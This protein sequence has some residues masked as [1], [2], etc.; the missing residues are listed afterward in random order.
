MDNQLNI[1]V[2][3]NGKKFN[4]TIPNDEKTEMIYRQAADMYNEAIQNYKLKQYEGVSEK[5]ILS[6]VAYNFALKFLQI[7][8]VGLANQ[9]DL[10]LTL[11]NINQSLDAYLE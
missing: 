2:K 9:E 8:D 10:L 1:S 11:Q 4:L 5:E 6:M 3:L 7:K